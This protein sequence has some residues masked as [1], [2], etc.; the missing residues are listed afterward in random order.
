VRFRHSQFKGFPFLS[1]PKQFYIVLKKSNFF[2]YLFMEQFIYNKS[3]DDIM[4]KWF[5]TF[6]EN[7]DF[8]NH[9]L[10]K[11]VGI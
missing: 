8:W 1:N 5:L 9:N 6:S 10:I 3:K 4:A 2:E 7:Y 11:R